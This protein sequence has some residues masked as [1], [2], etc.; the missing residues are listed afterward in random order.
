MIYSHLIKYYINRHFHA[1]VFKIDKIGISFFYVMMIY[2]KH[3]IQDYFCPLILT[4]SL[5]NSLIYFSIF[6]V[7]V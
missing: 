2:T 1:D 6:S 5:S 4:I 7:D 3:Q